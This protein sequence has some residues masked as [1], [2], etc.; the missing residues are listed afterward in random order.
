MWYNK[1]GNL[2]KKNST[3]QFFTSE[4]ISCNYANEPFSAFILHQCRFAPY[5]KAYQN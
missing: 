2:Y 1:Y 5:K 3:L 4:I